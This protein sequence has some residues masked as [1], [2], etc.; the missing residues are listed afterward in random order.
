MIICPARE[1]ARQTFEVIDFFSKVLEK[2]NFPVLKTVLCMGGVDNQARDI[3]RYTYA[4]V[5]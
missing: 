2:S 5:V 1:L 4:L 3:Q